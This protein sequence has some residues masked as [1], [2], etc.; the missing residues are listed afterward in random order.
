MAAAVLVLSMMCAAQ[1]VAL[2][3]QGDGPDGAPG[4]QDPSEG[5]RA[6]R[7][8]FGRLCGIGDTGLQSAVRLTRSLEGEW[9]VVTTGERPGP[10]DNAA[11][12]VWRES[13][14]MVDLHDAPGPT[15]HAGQMCFGA[16]GQLMVLIDDYM[17]IPNCGCLRSTSQTFD[18]SGKMIR[19]EQRYNSAETG[20]EMAAPE[21][22]KGFPEVY[23]F[24][25]VEQLPF[26]PLVKK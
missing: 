11:A 22:A 20:T 7:I 2:P 26:Y 8:L 19:R 23:E 16:T 12:R 13:T 18:E 1:R 5:A 6:N 9:K 10:K 15:M 4:T 3:P 24:R 25:R 17:D 21:A 14:W